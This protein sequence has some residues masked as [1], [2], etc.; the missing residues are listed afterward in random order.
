MNCCKQEQVGTKKSTAR[1][2]KRI[3]TLDEGRIPAKE[4]E[5]LMI[6]GQTRTITRKEH[7]RL[8]NEFG[9]GGFMAQKG[10]WNVAREKMLQ[11][12][13]ALTQEEGDIVREHKGMHEEN[14]LSSWEDVVGTERS[15]RGGKQKW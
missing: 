3:Q 1:C 14:F 11:D 7:R 2:K 9:R 15:Y 8:W 13:D 10:L 12:R 6:E 4:A 5:N